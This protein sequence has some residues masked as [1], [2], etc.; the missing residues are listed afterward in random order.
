V[1]VLRA[2]CLGS[3]GHC[4]DARGLVRCLRIGSVMS[5]QGKDEPA[6]TGHQEIAKAVSDSVEHIKQ[7]Y[8]WY[9]YRMSLLGKRGNR[10]TSTE[11]PP[12]PPTKNRKDSL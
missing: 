1:G 7:Q 6:E 4:T 12:R 3:S 10:V 2:R 5:G 8:R 9:L 11:V